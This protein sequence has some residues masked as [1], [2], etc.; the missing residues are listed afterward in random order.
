MIKNLNLHNLQAAIVFAAP[1][2]LKKNFSGATLMQRSP[3]RTVA[4]TLS[5]AFYQIVS[6]FSA[7]SLTA[8][9]VR[10]VFV[11]FARAIFGAR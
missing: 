9:K 10:G 11:R 2:H 5:F 4:Q 8:P 1:R 3:P 6:S 7:G